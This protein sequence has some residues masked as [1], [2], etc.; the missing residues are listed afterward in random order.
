V[1][2]TPV[3]T[4]PTPFFAPTPDAD[5]VRPATPPSPPAP[6][7]H[8][9][10]ALEELLRDVRGALA[11]LPGEPGDISYPPP[12]R[13]GL[14]E[15]EGAV[16]DLR[17]AVAELHDLQRV[18]S[19]DVSARLDSLA[20][21]L[22]AHHEHEGGSVAAAADD[23]TLQDL[24]DGLAGVRTDVAGLPD[25]LGPAV[26]SAVGHG[27]AGPSRQLEAVVTALADTTHES[28]QLRAEL[29]GLQVQL[30]AIHEQASLLPQ[31]QALLRD[32]T[33]RL[34]DLESLPTAPMPD[35][36]AIVD[37]RLAE[38]LTAFGGGL[39]ER[40]DA[41]LVSL[42]GTLGDI[43]RDDVAARLE[44]TERRLAQQLDAMRTADA[45]DERLSQLEQRLG[46]RVAVVERQVAV[47]VQLAEQRLVRHVDE[48]VLALAQAVLVGRPAAP[49]TSPITA[50]VT[51]PADPL[52]DPLPGR[53]T[54]GFEST[55]LDQP[56]LSATAPAPAMA[57][58]PA[59]PEAPELPDSPEPPA[60]LEP[61]PA[62][63]TANLGLAPPASHSQSQNPGEAG[64]VGEPT[65]GVEAWAKGDDRYAELAELQQPP[66]TAADVP[67]IDVVPSDVAA[68]GHDV[69]PD[70]AVLDEAPPDEAVLDEAP[71]DE[72]VL[73]E[74]P[75]DQAARDQAARDQAAR[76][77]AARDQAPPEDT[78]HDDVLPDPPAEA[79]TVRK[80]LF[81]R[82]G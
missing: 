45:G 61:V 77:Q 44:E 52:T 28:G 26:T 20:T 59:T 60:E 38:H 47:Q 1:T 43:P 63:G 42:Q 39:G 48:A 51:P 76:D 36:S 69:P 37:E 50:S 22:A 19:A 4:G 70:E 72:A 75:R 82:K 29:A 66:P 73:D 79:L 24:H 71:P 16:A 46:E 78:T 41:Q 10:P 7:G 62:Y 33:E 57:E 12:P 27:I 30:A 6:H 18:A 49:G 64:A 13:A 81:R 31:V 21:E 32:V 55:P 74:A 54:V 15:L 67:E 9:E 5:D 35:V 17:A 25:L 11:T 58:M 34:T 14:G 68:P 2:D 3:P 65:G 53:S 8:D 56:F 80:G 23:V 40:L